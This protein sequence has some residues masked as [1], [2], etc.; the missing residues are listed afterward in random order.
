[1]K[2]LIITALFFC[3]VSVYA[4]ENKRFI[5]VEGTGEIIVPADQI[6]FSVQ[7]K[8]IEAS[9]EK[10]KKNNDKYLNELLTILKNTGINSDDIEVS[11][12]TLGKNYEY[13]SGERIQNGFFTQVNVSFKLKDL[14]KYYELTD[15]LSSN[16]N[17]EILSSSYGLSNFEKHNKAA[18]IKALLD[19]KEKAGYMTKTLGV[20]LGEVL[21]IDEANFVQR[22]PVVF[23]SLA[24][25]G[26]PSESIAGKVTITRTVRVKF[27]IQ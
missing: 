18:Y 4:Q 3:F 2:Y 15:E 13:K 25:A 9:I 27:A 22:Y 19:A 11:P 12:L 10:S 26:Q 20:K 6:N 7:I 1:M 14:T 23:N 8:V 17:Y 16:N 21:E 24:K 5:N